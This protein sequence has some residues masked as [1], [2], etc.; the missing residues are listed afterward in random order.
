MPARMKRRKRRKSNKQPLILLSIVAV[1]M[2]IIVIA[3]LYQNQN[4]ESQPKPT[5]EEYFEI[6]GATYDGFIEENGTELIL[7]VLRFNLTA[8][9]GSA[10]NVIVHNLGAN[11]PFPW[12]PYVEL[13]TMLQGEVRTVQLNTEK[14]VYISLTDEGFPVRIRITSEETS[15]EPQEQFITIYL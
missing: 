5:T 7:H 9:G 13:G 12:E 2:V 3:A 8:V 6:S 1:V 11:E 10:H 4:Q 14:G 15:R